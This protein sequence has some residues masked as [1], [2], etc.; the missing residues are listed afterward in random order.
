MAEMLMRQNLTADLPRVNVPVLIL[1]PDSSPFLPVEIA[2]EIHSLIKGSEMQVLPCARHGIACSHA[3][4]GVT[5]L[6]D[7]MA[8]RGHRK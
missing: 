5:A 2:A 3:A 4:E 1:H 8:R 7:F 6:R